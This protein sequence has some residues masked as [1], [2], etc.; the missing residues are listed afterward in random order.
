[1]D[2]KSLSKSSTIH[3]CL[4]RIK[5]RSHV[6]SQTSV[7]ASSRGLAALRF[8]PL[9]S[10]MY[11]SSV[12]VELIALNVRSKSKNQLKM[13][14]PLLKSLSRPSLNTK[15]N[16]KKR[17]FQNAPSLLMSTHT[18]LIESRITLNLTDAY[19]TSLQDQRGT[20][21]AVS[22]ISSSR[23]LSISICRLMAISLTQRALISKIS[24]E[25]PKMATILRCR[26]IALP[27]K[28]LCQIK[29]TL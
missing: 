6:R 16:L 5:R 4:P 9:L 22:S 11:T 25:M 17:K 13:P 3:L 20:S 12:E 29:R 26:R 27:M 2:T 28:L 23:S 14:W 7:T 21:R 15:I 19:P 10:K 1:M 18:L 24:L 8:P